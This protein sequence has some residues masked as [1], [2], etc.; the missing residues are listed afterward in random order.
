MPKKLSDDAVLIQALEERGFQITKNPPVQRARAKLD[1]AVKPGGTIKIGLV[2]DTHLGNRN[3]QITSLTDFYRY[4]D[5]HGA[6]AFLHAGDFMDGLHVHRDSV[7]GQFAHGV[8]AQT[9]YAGKAYPKSKNGKT[10]FIDGNHDMWS[11]GNAGVVSGEGLAERRDDLQF[12]G[13]QSAFV[14]VG[15]LRI[16]LCHGSKGGGAYAKSYK[17][18]KL[19]EQMEVEER[20][21]TH[22]AFFGHWHNEIYAG[23]Y[24]GVFTWSLPCFQS[25]TGFERVIG[26][27]PTIGGL[28]LEVEFDRAM[29]VWDV[30]QSWR[31]YQPRI[32][33]YP[34]G[35]EA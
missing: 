4:A 32:G 20:S 29:R 14:E 33:D 10:L 26:K 19:L 28:F 2:S 1:L 30:R 5:D 8:K 23:R 6:Q 27:S 18:Q 12:L 21:Q 22:L 7:Y 9:D 24:Q 11:F 13:Q 3:Q 15:K 17:P 16:Y 31:Y 35:A 25:Q 34:G